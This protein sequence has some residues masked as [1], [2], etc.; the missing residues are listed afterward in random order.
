MKSALTVGCLLLVAL[1]AGCSNSPPL[2]T[3]PSSSAIRAAEAVGSANVPRAALHLQLARESLD[4]A[5]ELA[6]KGDQDEATS[7][8][9]RAEA[10]AELAILLAQAQGEKADAAEAMARVRQFRQDNQ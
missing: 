5:T 6:A 1:A 9:M 8:L 7:L 10:D 4:R 3:E 2:A